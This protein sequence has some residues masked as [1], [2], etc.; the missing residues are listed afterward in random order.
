VAAAHAGWVRGRRRD[1]RGHGRVD[2]VD[3]R[4]RADGA[5]SPKAELGK[6]GYPCSLNIVV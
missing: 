5:D 1:E 6:A 3:S 2:G 4:K